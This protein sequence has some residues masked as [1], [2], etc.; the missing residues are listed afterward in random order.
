MTHAITVGTPF[1]GYPGQVRRWFEGE[2]YLTGQNPP[3]VF[4]AAIS[5]SIV[6][7]TVKPTPV[8]EVLPARSDAETVN[9]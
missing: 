9:M 2:P 1:Y 7:T 5:E 3:N 8:L 6:A 4:T